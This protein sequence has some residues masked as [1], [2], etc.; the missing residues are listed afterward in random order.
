MKICKTHDK[1]II[2]CTNVLY[3][4]A[5]VQPPSVGS[6]TAEEQS[7]IVAASG[8]MQT[9]LGPNLWHPV[10]KPLLSFEVCHYLSDNFTQRP[11][12]AP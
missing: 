8:R 9:K 1:D 3:D 10:R 7:G 4:E 2:S 11:N 5:V 12:F 6:M